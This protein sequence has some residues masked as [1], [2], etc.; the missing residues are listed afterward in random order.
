[1]VLWAWGIVFCFDKEVVKVLA[2]LK[3]VAL[4]NELQHGKLNGDMAIKFCLYKRI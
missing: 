1:M 4:R 3:G 2:L